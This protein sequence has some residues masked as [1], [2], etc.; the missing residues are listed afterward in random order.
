MDEHEYI[1]QLKPLVIPGLFFLLLYP[2][3]LGCIYLFHKFPSLELR[4]LAGIYVICALGIL[5]L[6]VIGKSK[7]V[8]IKDQQIVFNSLLGKHVL[9]P[10]DIRRVAFYFDGKGQE[11]AQIRTGDIFYYLSEFYFPFPELMSDLETFIKLHGLRS[12]L[13]NYLGLNE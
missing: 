12:N 8:L 7:R 2:V 5:F 1:Y 6:W 13:Q 9:E 4:V 3:L 11:V 10:K